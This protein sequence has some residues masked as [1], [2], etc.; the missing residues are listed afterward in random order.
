MKISPSKIR[1][2]AKKGS[3]LLFVS[4]KYQISPVSSE[5]R[6]PLPAGHEFCA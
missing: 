6:L 3:F 2:Q 4:K 5:Q 1:C